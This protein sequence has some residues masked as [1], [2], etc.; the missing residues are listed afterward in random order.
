MFLA[1]SDLYIYNR[2]QL[3]EKYK[4]EISPVWLLQIL[5]LLF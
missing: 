4:Y 3:F 2:S 5:R 1:K